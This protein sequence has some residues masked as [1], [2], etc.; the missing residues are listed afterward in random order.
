[1]P[2]I[3]KPEDEYKTHVELQLLALQDVA[4]AAAALAWAR[5]DARVQPPGRELLVQHL[6]DGMALVPHL[7]E[8][9]TRGQRSDFGPWSF[10]D[11][12]LLRKACAPGVFARGQDPIESSLR[13]ERLPPHKADAGCPSDCARHLI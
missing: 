13:T 11:A 10:R 7:R 9:H 5:G 12:V 2:W 6:V 8:S 1:M 3:H 4:V